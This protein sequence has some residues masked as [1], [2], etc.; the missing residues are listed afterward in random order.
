MT[1]LGARRLAPTAI[2]APGCLALLFSPFAIGDQC[3]VSLPWLIQVGLSPT[4]GTPPCVDPGGGIHGQSGLRID[5]FCAPWTFLAMMYVVL[6]V[7][8]LKDFPPPRTTFF[9]RVQW[10]IAVL[11][12]RPGGS[13]HAG[14]PPENLITPRG[15][16]AVTPI[17]DSHDPPTEVLRPP[18]LKYLGDVF[19]FDTGSLCYHF[20]WWH[21]AP[22]CSL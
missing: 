1:C 21:Q 13:I 10:D 19:M 8:P 17:A 12:L 15:R 5:F 18:W 9:S 2:V 16:S 7:C 22:Y 6:R 11:P 4:S 14:P 20:P 3:M